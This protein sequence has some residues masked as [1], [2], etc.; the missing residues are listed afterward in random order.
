MYIGV[1]LLTF[2]KDHGDLEPNAC[3]LCSLAKAG[4]TAVHEK[5]PPSTLRLA[6]RL[7]FDTTAID[8]HIPLQDSISASNP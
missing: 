2:F 6:P 1:A 4:E 7:Q 8:T 5:T 3:V